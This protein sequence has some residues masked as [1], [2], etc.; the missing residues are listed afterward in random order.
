M[1]VAVL[2]SEDAAR[3]KRT[4]IKD[5]GILPIR[6]LFYSIF[7]ECCFTGETTHSPRKLVVFL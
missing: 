6:N 4:F 3:S 2:D 5:H 7:P 1:P